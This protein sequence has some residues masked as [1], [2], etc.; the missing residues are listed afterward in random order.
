MVKKNKVTFVIH[1]TLQKELR[2]KMITDNYGLRG[3]SKWVSEAIE[4]LLSMENY[5]ELVN[6][7]D[8]LKNFQK[9]ETITMD[10]VLKNKLDAAIIEIRKKYPLS[11]GVQSKIV[12]TAI[13]QK[14]LR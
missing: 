5:P 2:K 12:R 3:K 7:G 14:L 1:E 8:G 9:T 6:I 4:L 11:E 10:T 13:I